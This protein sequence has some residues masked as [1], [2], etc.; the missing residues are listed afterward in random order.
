M[1]EYSE[2]PTGALGGRGW[3][4]MSWLVRVSGYQNSP[5]E[6]N[7]IC[8]FTSESRERGGVTAEPNCCWRGEIKV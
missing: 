1:L 7:G 6:R 4:N 8:Y 2:C 3:G 5:E